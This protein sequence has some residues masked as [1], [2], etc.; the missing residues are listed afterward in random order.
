MNIVT[1]AASNAHIF[2]TSHFGVPGGGVDF[3]STSLGGLVK[4]I[5]G[6]IGIIVV[7]ISL[8]KA[9]KDV[10]AGSLGKAVKGVVGGLLVAVFL[11]NPELFYT[12]INGFS[13]L[14]STGVNTI[15][16]ILSSETP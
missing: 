16:E 3:F 8:V 7:L 15:T 14:V 6:V 10:F 2:A 4:T 1:L 11:F 13:D 9:F 5:L 12:L